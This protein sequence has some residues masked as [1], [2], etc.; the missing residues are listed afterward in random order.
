MK[1]SLFNLHYLSTQRHFNQGYSSLPPTVPDTVSDKSEQ[2]V[3]PYGASV[4][5]L[6]VTAPPLTTPLVEQSEIPYRRSG[7]PLFPTTTEKFKVCKQYFSSLFF[8]T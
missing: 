3:P 7:L 1:W 4:H 8:V 5:Q 6:P 2:A